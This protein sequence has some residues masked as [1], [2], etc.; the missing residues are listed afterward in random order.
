MNE[1]TYRQLHPRVIDAQPARGR[2]FALLVIVGS[3][4]LSAGIYALL[5]FFASGR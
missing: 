3:A 2:T 4:L 1:R 5:F